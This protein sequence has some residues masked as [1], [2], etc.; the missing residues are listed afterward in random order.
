[1][2][3]NNL[4]DLYTDYLLVSPSYITATGLSKAIDNKVSHDKITRLLSHNINNKT[5]WQ[6]VKPLVH[7]INS[8]EGLLNY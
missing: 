8:Y 7:E 5:L 6:E 4:L 3:V 2:N 1:M